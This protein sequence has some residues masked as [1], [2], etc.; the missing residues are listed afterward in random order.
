MRTDTTKRSALAL[1]AALWIPAGLAA[2]A[3]APAPPAAPVVLEAA[4]PPP[5]EA[6]PAGATVVR[7]GDVLQLNG[8][9]TITAREVVDGDVVLFN[10]RLLVEGEVR[11]DVTVARGDLVLERSGRI[12]GDATV[13]GGR[14]VNHGGSVGGEMKVVDSGKVFATSDGRHLAVQKVRLGGGWFAPIGEGLLGLME[15]LALGLVLAG[16]GVG[17]IFYGLPHLTRVS[18]TLRGEPWRAAGVGV[19]AGFLAVPA[20][21][22]GLVALAV[23]IIGLPFL[24]VYIPLFWVALMAAA[25]VGLVAV[26]HAL[27]ERTAEQHGSY[28]ARHRNAYT[29]LFTGLGLL[30]A[31]LFLSHLVGMTG[32][33]GWVGDLLGVFAW[34]VLWVSGSVGMG[35]VLL[36]AARRWRER[37]QMRVMA[38]LDAEPARA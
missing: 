5:A 21:I 33:L 16:I 35:A 1:A 7:Q 14:L 2:Q 19:A 13:T 3:E 23:T 9:R 30:L 12:A 26:A 18:E 38:D 11:G 28:D 37:R 6:P 4:V 27:G 36:V 8:N 29:Y 31:P 17:L 15:T 20:F 25:L 22:V 34:M 10:G 32:A 24:V